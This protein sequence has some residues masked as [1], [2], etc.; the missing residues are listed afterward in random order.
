VKRSS[1][2]AAGTVGATI[3][4]LS[5]PGEVLLDDRAA[6]RSRWSARQN[7]IFDELQAIFLA[8]GFRRLT[9]AD[10]V[11]RLHCSR[12]TL[13]SLAP[14]REE[15]VLIVVDRMFRH[16]GIEAR[17]RLDAHHDPAEALDEYIKTFTTTLRGANRA[18][19]EDLETYVPTRHVYDRHV[20]I[21]LDIL[22]TVIERGVQEGRFAP[23]SP[24]V[25]VE[26]LDAG[27]ERLRRPEVLVRTGLSMSDA[28]A[29]LSELIRHGL[30]VQEGA[31][32]RRDQRRTGRG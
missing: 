4:V 23:F 15:L 20:R 17:A 14:S 1:G 21:A 29:E 31:A 8:E 26:I 7:E 22:R 11:E 13:Y 32:V 2:T 19:T 25:V 3:V 24:A 28:V 6:T 18:F 16:M 9:I 27:V 30:V 5:A 10:L 12:R